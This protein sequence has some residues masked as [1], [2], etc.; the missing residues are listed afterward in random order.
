MLVSDIVN[1][2]YKKKVLHEFPPKCFKTTERHSLALSGSLCGEKHILLIFIPFSW[3]DQNQLFKQNQ[4]FPQDNPLFKHG[5]KNNFLSI[6]VLV[7]V[8]VNFMSKNK[9]SL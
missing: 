8:I 2:M 7:S 1:F 6:S 9:S 5:G 4:N 3:F